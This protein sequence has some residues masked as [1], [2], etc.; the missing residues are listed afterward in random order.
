MSENLRMLARY[1]AAMESGDGDA[2]YEFW[3]EDFVSHVT[4]RVSPDKVGTDV[5]GEE[6]L[7]VS[8]RRREQRSMH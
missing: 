1:S 5:R 7:V 2:V 8:S 4:A 6:Q 3:S